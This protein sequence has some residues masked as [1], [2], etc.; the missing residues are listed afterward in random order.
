M[1]KALSC[2]LMVLFAGI[3]CV[4][5]QTSRP[6]GNGVSGGNATGQRP[7][8][9]GQQRLSQE[10]RTKQQVDTLAKVLT[11]NASQKEKL[12]KIF[13]DN[14]AEMRKMRESMGENAD[15]EQMRTEMEKMRTTQNTKIKEVLTNEQFTKYQK[16]QESQPRFGGRGQGGP[17]GPG[18]GRPGGGERMGGGRPGGNTPSNR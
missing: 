16:W 2:V 1:K 10:Q 15:R 11:L 6:I 17:G 9:G 18:G 7:A 12:T 5:A 4:S 3:M 13:T 14:A 8:A